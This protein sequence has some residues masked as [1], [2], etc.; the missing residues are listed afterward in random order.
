MLDF[1]GIFGAIMREGICY[2]LRSRVDANTCFGT[3]VR[4]TCLAWAKTT[5]KG[6]FSFLPDTFSSLHHTLEGLLN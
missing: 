3:I 2:D 1:K 4:W 5:R 6:F